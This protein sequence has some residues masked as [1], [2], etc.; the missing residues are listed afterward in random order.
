MFARPTAWSRPF[1]ATMCEWLVE[2]VGGAPAG[3]QSYWQGRF[4]ACTFAGGFLGIGRTRNS[5]GVALNPSRDAVPAPCKVQ[6]P[7][8]PFS[9]L[10]WSRFHAPSACSF[11]ALRL[12]PC[13]PP[14]FREEPAKFSFAPPFRGAALYPSVM[15]TAPSGL[16]F[17][18]MHSKYRL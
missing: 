17:N 3:A 2:Q 12:S 8:D 11:L 4:A 16:T 15:L 10:S 18:F 5:W 6:L 14:T 13:L 7:L 9:R 1:G